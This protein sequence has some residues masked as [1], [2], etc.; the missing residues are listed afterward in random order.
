M[1]TASLSR[2]HDARSNQYISFMSQRAPRRNGHTVR[3]CTSITSIPRNISIQTAISKYISIHIDWTYIV[4][5]VTWSRPMRVLQCGETLAHWV[6]SLYSCSLVLPRSKKEPADHNRIAP[7]NNV[8]R[9][10]IATRDNW[11]LD[12]YYCYRIAHVTRRSFTNVR[13]S[14]AYSLSVSSPVSSSVRSES[15]K[16]IISDDST[17]K[18]QY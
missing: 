13:R 17:N 12:V 14:F 3:H 6:D 7:T 15:R 2:L 16:R 5:C 9:Y 4:Y 1:F 8:T 11:L 18:I 10:H